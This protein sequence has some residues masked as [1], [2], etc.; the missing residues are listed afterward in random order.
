MKIKKFRDLIFSSKLFQQLQTSL[1][2]ETGNPPLCATHLNF[3]ENIAVQLDG[4]TH[5]GAVLVDDFLHFRFITELS[6]VGFQVDDHL[7]ANVDVF[8]FT[9]L[10]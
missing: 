6:A 2:S 1:S 7:G 5:E 9:D 8:C 3:V 4:E 10:V